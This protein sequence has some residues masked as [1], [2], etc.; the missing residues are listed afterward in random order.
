MSVS[1][2]SQS[3]PRRTRGGL[4]ANQPASGDPDLDLGSVRLPEIEAPEL[5]MTAEERTQLWQRIADVERQLAVLG[6]AA[7]PGRTE[8]LQNKIANLRR[9][10]PYLRLREEM[11]EAL[12]DEEYSRAAKLKLQ[13]D[14][15]GAPPPPNVGAADDGLPVRD[16]AGAAAAAGG[17][18]RISYSTRSSATTNGVRVEVRSQFFPEQSSP[19]QQ[20]FVFVYRVK[21]TN[22]SPRTVQLISRKWEISTAGSGQPAQIVKGP[23]VVGQQPVLEPGE[24]FEY[25]S[26]C[27]LDTA[28]QDGVRV[29][30]RMQGCYVMASGPIGEKMFEV[31]IA[32][33][34]MILPRELASDARQ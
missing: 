5:D 30:G 13:M 11:E 21:I 8:A 19:P 17:E 28:P 34:Y 10:D 33:F 29:L 9:T 25:S 7:A 31:K 20:H 2:S 22:E 27:P 15:I 26:M 12:K 3:L 16:A 18:E 6:P 32:P 24:S 4:G 23:G 14:R 1:D